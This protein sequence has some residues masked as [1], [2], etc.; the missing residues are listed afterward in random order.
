MEIKSILRAAQKFTLDNSPAILTGIGVAGTIATA[1]LAG[2]AS[3]SSALIVKEELLIPYERGDEPE[4]T[5]REIVELVWKEFI[6]PAIVGAVTILAIIGANH[7]SS[8]RAAALA[9]AFKISEQMA[10]E[11]RQKTVEKLGKKDEEMMR[12]EILKEKL[13]R[14]GATDGL[15]V[16]GAQV[17]FWDPWS[18]RAFLSTKEKVAA[19]VN[20][21][22]TM[23]NNERYAS[24]SDFYDFL[25]VPKTGISD[26]FGWNSDELL[27]PWYTATLLQNGHS[28]IEIRYNVQPFQHFNKI[29]C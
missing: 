13:E 20:Q 3:Y 14:L 21:V 19:A 5:K 24:L 18:G 15:I 22:N 17:A 4:P 25:D 2:R 8:K 12:S 26:E 10:D 11:Y 23:I 6:P 29:G 7:V 16:E 9:A 1:I 27:D 28:A